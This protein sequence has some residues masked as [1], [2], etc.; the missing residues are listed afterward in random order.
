MQSQKIA[1]LIKEKEDLLQEK[2]T[3]FNEMH[4]N[5]LLLDIM[6][7]NLSLNEKKIS[8]F[9]KYQEENEQ[10]KNEATRKSKELLTLK[11][12]NR[13]LVDFKE[14]TKRVI[15]L[16]HEIKGFT[17]NHCQNTIKNSITVIPCG[18]SFCSSCEKGYTKEKCGACET[19][20]ESIYKNDLNE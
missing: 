20:I 1:I 8:Q 10:L 7:G 17:C 16:H 19:L 12:T 13:D 4:T 15:S 18:H 9:E 14:K 6:R 11:I 2:D 5:S 3:L